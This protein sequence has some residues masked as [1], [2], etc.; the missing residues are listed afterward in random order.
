MSILDIKE[1]SLKLHIQLCHLKHY[2]NKS[3][4]YKLATENELNYEL[5]GDWK[6]SSA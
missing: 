4:L 2:I 3:S 6:L 1:V 5:K